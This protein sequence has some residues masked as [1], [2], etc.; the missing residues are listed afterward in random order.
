LIIS[1]TCLSACQRQR[2]AGSNIS[3]QQ[4]GQCQS[5]ESGRSGG[6]KLLIGDH[7]K[8]VENNF[9]APRT[10]H[11]FEPAA[12]DLLRDREFDSPAASR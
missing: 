10:G 2:S 11:I 12:V 7:N 4:L 3:S 5:G 9:K 8:I 1:K 6:L